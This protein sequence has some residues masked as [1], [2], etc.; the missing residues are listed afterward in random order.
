MRKIY[1]KAYASNRIRKELKR[2]RELRLEGLEGPFMVILMGVIRV[3]SIVIWL[4][5]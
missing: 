2:T 1:V 5:V 3:G 4:V